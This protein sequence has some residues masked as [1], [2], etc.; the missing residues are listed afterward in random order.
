M[1][2]YKE[3][4]GVNMKIRVKYFFLSILIAGTSGNQAVFA[5]DA[6]EA[7][8]NHPIAMAQFI[9]PRMTEF[10]VSSVI[11]GIS[12]TAVEDLDFY[13]FF[14]QA[15]DVVTLDIDGGMGG[16]RSVDTI[17]AIFANMPDHRM[18]R[19]NDDSS[20]VDEGSVHRY[21]SRI[22]DFVLPSTGV[23]YVGVSHY[24]RYFRDGGLARNGRARNG[25]YMLVVSGVSNSVL[26]IN[27]SVKP[28][29]REIAPLNPR[30]KGR[31]P[32]VLLS[33]DDFNPKDVDV[34]SL[35]FGHGGDEESLEKCN[36]GSA[37]FNKDGIKDMICHFDNQM[38]EFRKG[39][40]EGVLKGSLKDGTAVEGRGLLKVVPEKAN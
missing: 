1:F 19:I 21:D 18:L 2:R 35:T 11:G 30:A 31:V 27:I 20:P 39:D 5:A 15:G 38:A 29:K 17:M 10:E 28:G 8:A 25:D 33:A 34:N 22:V 24:P 14:G 3:V 32:V 40:L 13:K 7:E 37:D 16:L 9:V 36:K 6:T 4:V 12:G 26:H 23:Y